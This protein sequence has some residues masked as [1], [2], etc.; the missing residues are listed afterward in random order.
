MS[1]HR[2]A[3]REP[4]DLTFDFDFLFFVF[5]VLMI[6]VILPQP[7]FSPAEIEWLLECDTSPKA[8]TIGRQP[9]VDLSVRQEQQSNS[10][11]VFIGL[12]SSSSTESLVGGRAVLAHLLH[13]LL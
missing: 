10:G 2:E 1:A 13:A 5:H 6:C 4:S 8:L 11:F 12:P 9:L 3:R 7:P